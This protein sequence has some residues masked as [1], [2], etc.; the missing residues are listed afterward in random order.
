MLIGIRKS[1]GTELG[2]VRRII[3]EV[4]EQIRLKVREK[5][6]KCFKIL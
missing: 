2:I 4:L 6:G 1:V 3:R 5:K